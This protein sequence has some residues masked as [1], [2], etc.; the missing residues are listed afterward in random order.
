[1]KHTIDYEVFK[2]EKVEHLLA[3]YAGQD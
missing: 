3:N 1:M 2:N